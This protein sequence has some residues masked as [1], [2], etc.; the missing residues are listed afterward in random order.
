MGRRTA[1]AA[2]L[3]AY[4]FLTVL[5]AQQPASSSQQPP[6]FRSGA[7]FVRVDVYP[8]KD[9]RIVPGLTKDDFQLFEDGDSAAVCGRDRGRC[10]QQDVGGCEPR[11][12]GAGRV[13]A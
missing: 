9:G 3:V 2:T 1:L 8:T 4:G 5:L 12:V 6:V 11:A 7:A 10:G 13:C